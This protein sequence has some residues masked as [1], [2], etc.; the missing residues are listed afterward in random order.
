[1]VTVY[2]TLVDAKSWSSDIPNSIQTARDYYKDVDPRRFYALIGPPNLLLS[3][4]T[5]ILFWK[6]GASLRLY[7]AASFVLYAAIVV[8]TFAYFIP[9]DLILFT[10][11]M[12]DHIDQI[13]TAASQWRHMNWL[14]TVLGFAPVLLSFKGLDSYY[15][16]LAHTP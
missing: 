6:N 1:M 12:H 5:I 11:P 9:R 10:W 2:N 13:R 14:R 15:R 8:L 4:L 7:F 16:T 3:L